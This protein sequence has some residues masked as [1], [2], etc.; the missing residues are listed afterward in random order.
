MR[1]TIAIFLLAALS[2]LS[3]LSGCGTSIESADQDQVLISY[4]N[5]ADSPDSL[6]PLAEEQC[7]SFER[8][9]V[10]RGTTLGQGTLGLLTALPLQADFEC[11]APYQF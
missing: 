1:G 7:A 4:H 6:Q 8:R 9:A 2:A 5:F 11:R 10:Y 3:V